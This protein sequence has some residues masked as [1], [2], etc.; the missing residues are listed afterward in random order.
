[1]GNAGLLYFGQVP[2]GVSERIQSPDF[3]FSAGKCVPPPVLVL[4]L[5]LPM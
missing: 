2:L 4:R 5:T 3:E 1:M